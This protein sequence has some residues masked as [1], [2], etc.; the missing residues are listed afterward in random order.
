MLVFSINYFNFLKHIEHLYSTRLALLS[1]VFAGSC[2]GH[3]LFPAVFVVSCY[4]LIWGSSQAALDEPHLLLPATWGHCWAGA[5]SGRRVLILQVH[6][7][8]RF[9]FQILVKRIPPSCSFLYPGGCLVSHL[10]TEP[11]AESFYVSGRVGMGVML[12]SKS[13]LPKDSII[14]NFLV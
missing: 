11:M 1:G 2:S 14:S 6:S 9:S 10:A 8:P 5:L 4:S 12:A 3:L 13:V 7:R